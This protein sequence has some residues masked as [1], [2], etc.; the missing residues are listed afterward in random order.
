MASFQISVIIVKG[1]TPIHIY[2][3]GV[4]MFH[5]DGGEYC[6]FFVDDLNISYL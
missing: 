4:V 6:Q 5:F 2:C 1:V 3:D